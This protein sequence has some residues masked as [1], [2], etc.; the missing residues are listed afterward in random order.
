MEIGANIIMHTQGARPPSSLLA[1]DWSEAG[2][3]VPP[4]LTRPA[5]SCDAWFLDLD[6]DGAN[7]ILLVYGTD[8]RW[9]AAVMKQNEQGWTAAAASF[10]SPSCRGTLASLHSGRFTL[11]DPLPGVTSALGLN[12]AATELWHGVGGVALLGVIVAMTVWRGFQRFRW[13]RD[14]GRQVQWLYLLAGLALFPVFGLHGTLGAE[15]AAEF[16]VHIS[17][18]QLLAAGADLREALP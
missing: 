15:L 11:A 16:G 6:R 17:A 18:D 9:W 14:M 13:R 7:E 8:A 1:Q 2:Q 5:L 12:S 4:R 10:A 3:D